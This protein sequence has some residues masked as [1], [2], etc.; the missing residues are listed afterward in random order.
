LL[1]CGQIV[2]V[3]GANGTTIEHRQ[4][5][6][7]RR[8]RRAC[9]LGFDEPEVAFAVVDPPQRVTGV[10]ESRKF[11]NSAFLSHE[12]SLAGLGRQQELING[13]EA[14]Q[15]LVAEGAVAAGQDTLAKAAHATIASTESTTYDQIA[16]EDAHV[17]VVVRR[18]ATNSSYY[19]HY[20]SMSP[21]ASV[22]YVQ[23]ISNDVAQASPQLVPPLISCVCHRFGHD[24]F[25]CCHKSII[26]YA[27]QLRLVVG[28]VAF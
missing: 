3:G 19:P 18:V 15:P 20:E 27:S 11:D 12:R 13:V 9:S 26:A 2:V 4:V 25:L 10:V 17:E 22:G 23:T 28:H 16:V 1:P 7:R 5:G 21:Q 8:T 14:S 24:L 6:G